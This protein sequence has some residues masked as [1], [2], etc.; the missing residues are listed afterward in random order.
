MTRL[1]RAPSRRRRAHESVALALAVLRLPVEERCPLHGHN[2]GRGEP[3]AVSH[4]LRCGRRAKA[5]SPTARTSR[6]YSLCA[7]AVWG[8]STHRNHRSRACARREVRPGSKPRLGSS[9]DAEPNVRQRTFRSRK[10]ASVSHFQRR[11][12]SG[13]NKT[14]TAGTRTP[15]AAAAH[16]QQRAQKQSRA[17]SE[18]TQL[19]WRIFSLSP[20]SSLVAKSCVRLRE[21][22]RERES[23]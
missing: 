9:P 11:A 13:A 19:L 1:L 16:K 12:R 4:R 8:I 20:F 17:R 15:L 6:G 21:R 5:N 3:V 7:C 10:R 18:Q 14:R 2:G 23:E 22:E